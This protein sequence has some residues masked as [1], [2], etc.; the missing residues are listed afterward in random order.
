MIAEEPTSKSLLAGLRDR[1][2]TAWA[3]VVMVYGPSIEIWCKQ[4]RLPAPETDEVIQRVML[5]VMT[6]AADYRRK[7]PKRS[8]R[9]WLWKVTRNKLVDTYR[10]VYHAQLFDPAD[11]DALL[12]ADGLDPAAPPDSKQLIDDTLM[13][14]I[15][16]VR[17]RS[18]KQTWAIFWRSVRGEGTTADIAAD[19]ETS[20]E[21]VRQIKLRMLARIHDVLE[22]TDDAGEV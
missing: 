9:K 4:S 14:A 22:L 11:A 21:N 8:F 17:G 13:R 16:V 19:F 18:R 3:R 6:G 10:E 12:R 2:P 7:Y 1:D 20:Q 15:D 5:A